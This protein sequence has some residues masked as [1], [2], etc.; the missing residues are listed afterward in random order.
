MTKPN[1]RITYLD[2]AAIA[3]ALAD[4]HAQPKIDWAVFAGW[5]I[6]IS[7]V[8]AFWW[9]VFYYLPPVR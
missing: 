1:V 8:V 7:G 5:V 4:Q 9:W 6:L 2:R 3:A